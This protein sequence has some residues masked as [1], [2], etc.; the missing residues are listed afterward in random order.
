MELALEAAVGAVGVS[1]PNP[2]VGAV[3]VKDGE[4]V[5]QGA[6]QAPGQAHAEVMALKAA[7]ERARGA[8]LVVTLEPCCHFG[9]T[10]PCTSAILAAGIRRVFFAYGD[11]NPVVRGK[12]RQILEGAGV[13]VFEG[14]E[15]CGSQGTFAEVSR[16][17]EGYRHFVKTGRPLVELKVAV[18]SNFALAQSGGKPMKITGAQADL[19]VHRLRSYSDAILVGVRTANSD[20]PLLNVRLCAG[21]SPI[22]VLFGNHT[23]AREDLRLLKTGPQTLLFSHSRP[24]ASSGYAFRELPGSSFSENWSFMISE[25]SKLGMHRLMVEPGQS[26]SQKILS[27]G[28]WDRLDLIVS[29]KVVEGGLKF[30]QLSLVPESR[31]Q[32]GDD[33]LL[34][35]RNS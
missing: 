2:A 23:P 28:L 33:E 32:L 16:F 10:P 31:E 34:V 18:T 26:L 11:P 25:L 24:S 29:P 8:D 30:P 13:E 14:V 1:R 35:Y 21:N 17:F 3:V 20:D 22:R 27:S 5:S 12:S 9:R 19:W 4:L 6:T 15:A 7:G